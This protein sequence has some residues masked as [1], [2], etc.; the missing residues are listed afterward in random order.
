[1]K[2]AASA[3]APGRR[4]LMRS[5]LLA[6]AAGAMCGCGRLQ[7]GRGLARGVAGANP[8]VVFYVTS[9]HEQED[10][11]LRSPRPSEEDASGIA[12]S[13]FQ[14]VLRAFN[15]ENRM[16]QAEYAAWYLPNG[17]GNPTI[18]CWVGGVPGQGGAIDLSGAMKHENFDGAGVLGGAM[19]AVTSAD[20]SVIGMPIDF[21]LVAMAYDP[22]VLRSVG[23][24][25][26]APTGWS[27]SEFLVVVDALS[28][29]KAGTVPTFGYDLAWPGGFGAFL[30]YTE[31]CGGSVFLGS[32]VVLT[33]PAVLEGLGAY[34]EVLRATWVGM[35]PPQRSAFG[36]GS[37][38][39]GWSRRRRTWAEQGYVRLPVMAVR[40][41]APAM[42][43]VAYVPTRAPNPE[44]GQAFALWL[45]TAGGQRA[46]TS[47]GYPGMR[48]GASSGPA[49]LRTEETGVL[50]EDLVFSPAA[51]TVAVAALDYLLFGALS[52]PGK[53][54][55]AVLRAIESALNGAEAGR[56]PGAGF[57]QAVDILAKAGVPMPGAPG[58]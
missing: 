53:E 30:G 33:S 54:Q 36:L 4:Q 31:G 39:I 2:G 43:S 23:V 3:P 5:S 26:P 14:P 21:Q 20:G 25:A 15:E 19:A 57:L 18:S 22:G 58:A 29:A 7:W 55:P 45:L 44:A 50:P 41:A 47:L 1:M 51:G 8:R 27:A 9:E 35:H 17:Y 52:L 34:S 16:F 11:L 13:L 42:V 28:G 40:S 48:T 10:A 37:A 6:A 56:K 24:A 38:S 12:A 46:L 49:W 32:S